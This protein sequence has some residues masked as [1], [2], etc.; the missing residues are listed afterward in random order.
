MSAQLTARAGEVPPTSS[1]SSAAGGCQR[2]MGVFV[3]G[4]K[5]ERRST[6]YNASNPDNFLHACTH[7]GAHVFACTGLLL[8]TCMCLYG[9]PT[10]ITPLW[11]I[12]PLTGQENACLG[13]AVCS[14][15]DEQSCAHPFCLNREDQDFQMNFE[16]IS[17]AGQG[18][19]SSS[20]QETLSRIGH[21]REQYDTVQ[22]FPG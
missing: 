11:A 19:S 2:G 4:L 15:R 21:I 1:R 16:L 14:S 17:T 10:S 8:P 22:N 7:V 5:A 9:F 18:S 12:H 20:Q 6:A 13:W 3:I